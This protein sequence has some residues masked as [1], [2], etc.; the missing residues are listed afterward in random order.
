MSEVKEN[1][2]F[3]HNECISNTWESCNYGEKGFK[4]LCKTGHGLKERCI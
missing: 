4:S 1:M 3:F 2:C